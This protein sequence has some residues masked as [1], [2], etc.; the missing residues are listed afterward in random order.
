MLPTAVRLS[1]TLAGDED[2]DDREVG[3]TLQRVVLPA[4]AGAEGGSE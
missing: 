4:C 3:S 2:A 1:L